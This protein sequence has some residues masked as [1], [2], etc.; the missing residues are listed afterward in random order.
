MNSKGNTLISILLLLLGAAFVWLYENPQLTTA[1]VFVCGL[2]FALPSFILLLMA[3]F[4]GKTERSTPYRAV[5][6]LCG[7]G[8]LCLGLAIVFLPQ[9]FRPLLVYPFAALLVVGGAF[10]V[11]L[12]SHAKRPVDYPSWTFIVP[13]LVLVAGVVLV[14]VPMFREEANERWMVL[15]TGVCGILYG[16]NGIAGAILSARLPRRPGFEKPAKVED[17]KAVEGSAEVGS[18]PKGGAE[19]PHRL[20]AEAPADVKRENVADVGKGENR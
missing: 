11:L 8:G 14:A 9:V 16:L 13:I 18:L 6:I 12:L 1:I 2:T 17:E 4:T 19:L 20:D 5:Q 10:Q 3:F 7:I 15:V